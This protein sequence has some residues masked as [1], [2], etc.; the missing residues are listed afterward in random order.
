L[1]INQWE[2]N[3]N[4]FISIELKLEILLPQKQ[5]ER[6]NSIFHSTC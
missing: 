4:Y 5:K 2:H 1:L 3:F 6:K